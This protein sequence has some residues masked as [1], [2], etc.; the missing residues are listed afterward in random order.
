MDVTCDDCGSIQAASNGRCELCGASLREEETRAHRL[1][2]VKLLFAAVVA[3]SFLCL[4]PGVIIRHVWFADWSDQSFVL[5]YISVWVVG[6]ILS[7]WYE[8]RDDYEFSYYDNPLTLRDNRD[9]AHVTVGLAL[10]PMSVVSGLWIG[11]F[12]AAR[13]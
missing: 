9:R 2:A 4:L 3:T 10:F 8:P 12:K 5:G 7:N 13:K 1:S 11:A 6:S